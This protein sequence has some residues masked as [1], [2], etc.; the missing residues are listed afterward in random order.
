MKWIFFIILFILMPT[1]SHADDCAEKK[2]PGKALE[3]HYGSNYYLVIAATDLRVFLELRSHINDG[4]ITKTVG[5][6]Q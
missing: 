6:K 5:K 4:S 2:V 1:W 3:Y